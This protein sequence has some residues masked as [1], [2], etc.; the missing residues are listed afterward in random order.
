LG[1][2]T[3]ARAEQVEGGD[4]VAVEGAEQVLL[5][6]LPDVTWLSDAES[7]IDVQAICDRLAA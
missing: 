4:S 7:V 3:E 2:G 1:V 6:E 5:D